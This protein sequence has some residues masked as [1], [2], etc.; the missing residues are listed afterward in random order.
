METGT[1]VMA[2]DCK[3]A[4]FVL[5]GE[6]APYRS[7]AVAHEVIC[8]CEALP[9]KEVVEEV[10]EGFLEHVELRILCISS[11]IP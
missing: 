1:T 3:W 8:L 4:L 11:S 5:H 9:D 6:V 7:R 2:L 10:V